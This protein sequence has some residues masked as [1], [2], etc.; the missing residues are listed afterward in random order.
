MSPGTGARAPF[1]L[2]GRNTIIADVVVIVC[3]T[4][5]V[6]Q[7]PVAVTVA[8]LDSLFWLPRYMPPLRPT[9]ALKRTVAVTTSPALNV[10]MKSVALLLAVLELVTWSAPPTGTVVAYCRVSVTLPKLS[11]VV[12]VAVPFGAT[13]STWRPSAS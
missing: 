12:C 13:L 9:A 6:T 8:L 2:V 10:P 4:V 3:V 11:Y 7:P 5:I 1:W